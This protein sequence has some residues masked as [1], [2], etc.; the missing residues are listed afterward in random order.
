MRSNQ[1]DKKKSPRSA[2]E[3][4]YLR[5]RL[6]TIEGQIKGISRMVDEDKHCDDILIQLSAVSKSIK[7]LSAD[8]LK[9]YFSDYVIKDIKNNK[10]EVIDDIM[11]L[12]R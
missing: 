6:N 3:K 8:I 5:T 1:K 12:N 2:E 11:E 9:G 4:K 7:S 10:I